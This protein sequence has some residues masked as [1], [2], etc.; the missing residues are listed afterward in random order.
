MQIGEAPVPLIGAKEILV[1]VDATS[2]CGTDIK[3][4]R[5][6]HRKLKEGQTIILGHEFVGTIEQAGSRVENYAVGT[7]VG[8]APN[9]GCGYCEMCDRGLMNMCP[10]Y[11]AFGI[12][13]DGSHTEYVRIPA[14]AIAQGNVVPLSKDLSPTEAALAEPLSCAINGIRVSRLRQG[15]VVLIYGA[16][17]MGLLNLMLA[18]ISG[19][20]QV[21]A[22]DPNNARLGKAKSLGASKTHNPSD[23]P[24]RDWVMDETLGRGVDVVI[25]A[26][27]AAQIQEEAIQVLAPLGR[28]CLFAGLPS[29]KSTVALDTNRI[30]YRSLLVT[31]MTGGSPEDYRTAL[32]LIEAGRVDV[33]RVI[34]H[35]F[36]VRDLSKAYDVA[37]SGDGMKVVLA[38]EEWVDRARSATSGAETGD[39]VANKSPK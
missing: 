4:V 28:L 31:G 36:S 3:I 32:K 23:G 35:V 9:I 25:A 1:R 24:V 26:A 18:L 19:A 5:R 16:G 2:I 8:L 13:R 15:D 12:D 11:S 7:R 17:P 27:P 20:S 37:L 39:G 21:F 10:D 30:H 22:V 14:L 38:T 34:S 33:A 29:G 6:G